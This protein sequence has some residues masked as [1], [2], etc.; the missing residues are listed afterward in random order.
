MKS[1]LSAPVAFLILGAT[2]SAAQATTSITGGGGTPAPVPTDPV[3]AARQVTTVTVTGA[4]NK[5]DHTGPGDHD[6][7]SAEFRSGVGSLF[8]KAT[9]AIGGAFKPEPTSTSI[10]AATTTSTGKSAAGQVVPP[11]RDG[12]GLGIGVLMAGLAGLVGAGLVL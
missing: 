1:Y 3:V 9:S 4:I 7:D 8:T 12:V 11:G 10:G 2:L 6:D 5:A